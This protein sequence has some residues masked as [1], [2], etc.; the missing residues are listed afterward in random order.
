MHTT[1]HLN[2]SEKWVGSLCF[3]VLCVIFVAGLWPFHAPRNAVN[4]LPGGGLRFGR[5]GSVVSRGEFQATSAGKSSDTIEIWLQPEGLR[6]SRAILS[7][8]SPAHPLLPFVVRQNRDALIVQEPNQDEKG[9]YHGAWLVVKGA[10]R[11]QG[12]QFVTVTLGPHVTEVYLDGVLARTFLMAGTPAP[13]AG[14]LVVGGSPNV[15]DSWPGKIMGLAIYHR[16]ISGPEI[17]ADYEHWMNAGYP[18]G[19]ADSSLTA[20]YTFQE[21]AGSVAHNL[22]DPGTDLLIPSNFF[23]LHPVFLRSTWREYRGNWA[24]WQDIGVNIAGFIPLGF[25][26]AAYSSLRRGK[27]VLAA[28]VIAGFLTSLTIEVLQFFLPTRDS[29]TTDLMT[30]TLG[31]AIGALLYR[32]SWAQQTLARMETMGVAGVLARNS[33]SEMA[34]AGSLAGRPDIEETNCE[35]TRQ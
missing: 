1:G 7:F 4:W 11:E 13:L 22:R 27:R 20:L 26:L 2:V 12:P 30:N 18:T 19:K 15:A 31:T 23:V 25:S 6:R 35:V 10:F 16:E 3:A 32:T 28:A 14:R 34:A 8:D 29:G 5:F 21:G 17:V 24:Y 9:M 33:R